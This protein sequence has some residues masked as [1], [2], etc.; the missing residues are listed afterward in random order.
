MPPTALDR[1]TWRVNPVTAALVRAIGRRRCRSVKGYV[2]TASTGRCGTATLAQLLAA[3][4]G[5]VSGHEP[6]P[7]LRHGD[8][9]RFQLGDDG[10]LHRFFRH[11]KLP[12][13]LLTAAGHDWY[14]ET[15]H[16]FI[17]SFCEA[18][19]AEFGD[20]L[21]VVHLQRDPARVAASRYVRGDD[22]LNRGG[23]LVPLHGAR[24]LLPLGH[25]LEDGGEFAGRYFRLLWYCYEVWARTLRF[26][27]RHPAVR[28]HALT[29]ADLNDREH[30]CALL[31]GIGITP[32]LEALDRKMAVR[33]NES[34]VRP[35][36]P[37]DVDHARAAAG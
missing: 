2:F 23:H 5:C 35:A 10:L 27:R 13:I 25:L 11:R 28:M 8:L 32:D 12:R 36:I 19:A 15:S 18:A 7:Q 31:G 21:H 9:Q 22:P 14:C 3:G 29:T 37:A 4:R 24:T 33:W 6:V 34:P 20:R 17:T 26:Q 16:L 30:V 1:F